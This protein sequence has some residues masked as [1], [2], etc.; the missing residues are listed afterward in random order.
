MNESSTT[1]RSSDLLEEFENIEERHKKDYRTALTY[2]GMLLCWVAL[3][4]TQ[5]KAGYYI[6]WAKMIC[7]VA[8]GVLYSLRFYHKPYKGTMDAVKLLLLLLWVLVAPFSWLFYYSHPYMPIVAQY[9]NS[10]TFF[11]LI[12]LYFVSYRKAIKRRQ[13]VTIIISFVLLVIAFGNRDSGKAP[14]PVLIVIAAS[15]LSFWLAKYFLV[16]PISLKIK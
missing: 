3:L 2:A 7:Q 11:T 12:I 9:I 10:I 1:S 14:E 13:L 4:S 16:K 8:F 5:F 6:L 15:V